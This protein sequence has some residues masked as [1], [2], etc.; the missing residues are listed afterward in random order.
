MF[1]CNFCDQDFAKRKE[2]VLHKHQKYVDLQ[3]Q[4]FVCG[5]CSNTFTLAKNLVRHLKNVHKFARSVRCNSCQMFF[6]LEQ[7]LRKH[8]ADEHSVV[9]SVIRTDPSIFSQ[10]DRFVLERERKSVREHFQS[11]R[12]KINDGSIFDPFEFLVLQERKITDFIT[13][14]LHDL[15]TAKFG[16]CIE[17]KFTKPLTDDSTL[18]FFHSPMESLSTSLTAEEYFGHIDKLLTKIKVFCTAGSGWVIEKLNVVELKI[19]KYSPLRA[20]SYIATPPELETQRKSV[21]NIKNMKDNLCFIYS[22]LA[23]LFP[24]EQNQ[25]RPQSY[26]QH[27]NSLHFNPR[28]MTVALADIPVFEKNNHLKI[29]V[30]AYECSKVYPAYISKYKNSAKRIILLLLSD[31]NN[32][33]YC[34]IKNLDRV[35]KVL[36]RSAATA[37]SK[38]NVRK[39]CERCLQTVAREK[40]KLHKSLWEHHQPQVIEMPPQGSTVKFKNWQK[41]FKCPFV[42]YADL[43]ALDV[44]TEDF[45]VAEELLETGLNKVGASSC[46]TE[47]QYP[48]S[49]GAVLVDSRSSSV[50]MEQ[51]YRGEDCCCSY[52]NFTKMAEM[53][54]Q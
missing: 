7:A 30:L 4:N 34:L 32:W 24:F 26:R 39:F 46:V 33:H 14:K 54:R 3:N 1:K 29:N 15:V 41:T 21:L 48:C 42:V 27:I 51:F 9:G 8:C 6:G 50:K 52:A 31:E 49:F 12:L 22:V 38:N 18:C 20:A 19:S 16:I 44:R 28:K 11:F 17:V 10:E 43:E 47:N 40:F 35:L 5:H 13:T 45:E 37:S 36:L 53:G 2:L 25:E 23:A